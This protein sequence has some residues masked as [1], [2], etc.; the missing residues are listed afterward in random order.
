[1]EERTRNFCVDDVDTDESTTQGVSTIDLLKSVLSG[2]D[3]DEADGDEGPW[4]ASVLDASVAA[5]NPIIEKVV[6]DQGRKKVRIAEWVVDHKHEVSFSEK[7]WHQ[8][9][10][11]DRSNRS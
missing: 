5:E 4:F 1:M 11:V 3:N 9:C 2:T 7:E 6:S 8:L 10:A